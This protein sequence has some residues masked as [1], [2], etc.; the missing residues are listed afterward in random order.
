MTRTYNKNRVTSAQ[1]PRTHSKNRVTSSHDYKEMQLAKAFPQLR[2]LPS[3]S[4]Q[5]YATKAMR[6][7]QHTAKRQDKSTTPTLSD[8]L[9][10]GYTFIMNFLSRGCNVKAA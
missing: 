3:V 6:K 1:S 2:T 9:L 4:N 8:K 7:A 10:R 5:K